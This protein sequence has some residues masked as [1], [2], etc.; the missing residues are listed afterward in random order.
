MG[1]YLLKTL[2]SWAVG[3]KMVML[4]KMMRPG[5]GYDPSF[6]FQIHPI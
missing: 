2:L 1:K 6:D 4:M 3:G 5:R